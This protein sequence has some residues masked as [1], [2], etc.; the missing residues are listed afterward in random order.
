[1]VEPDY[2]VFFKKYNISRTCLKRNFATTKEAPKKEKQESE[3]RKQHQISTHQKKNLAKVQTVNLTKTYCRVHFN[4]YFKWFQTH[5][6]EFVW[7]LINRRN[8]ITVYI[9]LI[10]I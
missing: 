5:N 1:M 10:T 3:Y 4:G 2:F 9:Y 7:K 6:Q 8:Y